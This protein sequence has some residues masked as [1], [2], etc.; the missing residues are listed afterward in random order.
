[1]KILSGQ[2]PVCLSRLVISS[3]KQILMERT[4]TSGFR[5]R[6]HSKS[7]DIISPILFFKLY[8]LDIDLAPGFFRHVDRRVFMSAF[9]MRLPLRNCRIWPEL[10]VWVYKFAPPLDWK[11][12]LVYFIIKPPYST[13]LCG[14][15][16]PVTTHVRNVPLVHK[17]KFCIKFF[18]Y[19]I[20]CL[21]YPL[22]KN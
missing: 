2:S 21:E 3:F 7:Y 11:W 17:I 12:T 4:T 10:A 14:S 15:R 16:H 22:C 20:L 5:G 6:F 9:R 8:L 19:K 18:W 13:E 1:M